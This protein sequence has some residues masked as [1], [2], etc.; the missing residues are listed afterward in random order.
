MLW[1][2][3]SSPSL[4]QAVQDAFRCAAQQNLPALPRRREHR[5]LPHQKHA[6]MVPSFAGGSA[7]GVSVVLVT[8]LRSISNCEVRAYC[9][10]RDGTIAM[11]SS[12]RFLDPVPKFLTIRRSAT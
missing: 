10:D 2:T 12:P 7:I 9:T 5:A 4:R 11:W 8:A 6:H 1:A 3:D